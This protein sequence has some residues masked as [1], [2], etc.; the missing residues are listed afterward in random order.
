M[1]RFVLRA[2]PLALLLVASAATA[3]RSQLDLQVVDMAGA[4][5]GPVN[6]T[7]TSPTGEVT[8]AETRKNGRLRLRLEPLELPYQL[9]LRKEGHPDRQVEVKMV[10][11]WDRTFTVQLWDEAAAT[12]QQAIDNFNEAIGRIQAGDA[13]GALPLFQQAVELD[14][15]LAAAHRTISAILHSMGKLEEAFEPLD[16]Y[17]TME[18]L[19]PEFAPMAYDIFRAA[20]DPRSEEMKQAAVAAGQGAEIAPGVFA[21]GVQ[22]VRAGDD[23][24]AIELFREAASLN[25]RLHQA[26]RNIGTLHFNNAR[27]EEALVELDRT[28][29]LDPR[30]QEALRMKFFSFAATG[31]LQ[32]SIEAGAAWIAVNPTAGNQVL[33]EGEKL[34]TNDERGN[35]KLYLES[36]VAWDANQPR[37]HFL[38]GM[39][40]IG[41]ADGALARQHLEKFL[42]MAPDHEDAEAARGALEQL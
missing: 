28:L 7:V 40:Y 25:P 27:F 19:P 4:E 6:V 24:R 11:G 2:L 10:E 16:K 22:A 31:K 30:N 13:P 34:F 26:Y 41:S 20:G 36:L 5:L 29:E 8:E 21:E 42:E 12:R 37:A 14:P 32:E 17:M 18:E 15:T 33:F 39:L 35:A 23:D 3:Q 1:S 9:L 38:L